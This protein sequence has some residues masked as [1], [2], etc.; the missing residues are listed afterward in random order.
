MAQ[1]G[2]RRRKSARLVLVQ[3]QALLLRRGLQ[4]SWTRLLCLRRMP[5]GCGPP[6][7]PS[8]DSRQHAHA[9]ASI[10]CRAPT[11]ALRNRRLR[12]Q[13]LSPMQRRLARPTHVPPCLKLLLREPEGGHIHSFIQQHRR[14]PP[15]AP[16]APHHERHRLS[17][18]IQLLHDVL[19]RARYAR[20]QAALPGAAALP[21]QLRRR[22]SAG[23]IN[24][25]H[26]G[27]MRVCHRYIKL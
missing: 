3:R 7:E 4:R 24:L 1:A 8:P 10:P 15:P 12:L 27:S 2:H 23:Q 22:V 26:G 18:H 14:R 21:R 17:Q 13:R 19:Q 25:V 16:R 9:P 11:P 20:G 5:P 6:P